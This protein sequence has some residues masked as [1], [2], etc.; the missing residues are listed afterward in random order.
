MVRLSHHLGFRGGSDGKESVC[1]ADLGSLPGLA[2]SPREGNG[3]PFKYSYLENSIN[4]SLAGTVHTEQL[5]FS[6]PYVATEEN[7]S[8]DCTDL[9]QQS[10]ISAS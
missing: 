5:T 6:H 7:L 10:N 8:F 4:G 1:S 9:C 2:R 3:N